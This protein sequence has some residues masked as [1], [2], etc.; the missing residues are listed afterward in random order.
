VG[1][2]AVKSS[3]QVIVGSGAAAALVA[4]IITLSALTSGP[5]RA[6]L[7]KPGPTQAA[8]KPDL[9]GYIATHARDTDP[10]VQDRV[11][12]SR[13]H[14]AFS[15]ANESWKAPKN[16]AKK[17]AAYEAARVTFLAAANG[18]KGTGAMDPNYGTVTD[19]AAYQAAVCLAA[20]NKPE[21]AKAEFIA[22]LRNRKLSPLC[23]AC[24]RRL[25]RLNGGKP[26]T[27]DDALM[28]AATDAQDKE[29]KFELSVCGPK[30]IEALLGGRAS[31]PAHLANLPTSLIAQPPNYKTI[32]KLCGTTNN[33]TTIEGMRKG[34]RSLGIMSYGV[35]LNAADFTK[36]KT[37]AILLCVGHYF[38]ITKIAKGR[39]ELYDPTTKR[40][41]TADLPA[42]E[43]ATFAANVITFEVPTLASN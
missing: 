10:N 25:G 21:A 40:T 7:A 38:L 42:P 37:P 18:P 3:T 4:G 20:E 35:Q 30:A 11:A 12:A 1:G 23:K 14:L 6:N 41:V 32:A 26:N 17:K 33:G 9:P 13:M 8:T 43:E 2:H 36:L 22:F 15:Q 29:T 28:Q 31:S 19:Q 16:Q 39:F 24:Y 5:R 27:A 34:L